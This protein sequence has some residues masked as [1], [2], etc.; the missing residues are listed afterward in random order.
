MENGVGVDVGGDHPSTFAMAG[1]SVTGCV[2]GGVNVGANGTLKVSGAPVVTGNVRDGRACNVYL[3]AGKTITVVG[4][5]TDGARIGVTTEVKPTADSS[6]VFTSGFGANNPGVDPSTFFVSDDPSYYVALEGGEAVLKPHT[7]A[8]QWESSDNVLTATCAN[9]HCTADGGNKQTLTLVAEG[10]TYDGRLA[11]ATVQ[12]S[13]GWAATGAAAGEVA[14]YAG[15][16]SLAVAPKDAGTY[17]ARVTVSAAGTPYELV[18]PFSIKKASLTVVARD[19]AVTFGEAPAG[20]GVTYAGFA[21]SE[22]KQVLSGTLAYEFGGCKAGSPIGT[23]PITPSGLWAPNYEISYRAG[24][25]TVCA[26]YSCPVTAVA[27]VQRKGSLA[28][29][30]G[31]GKVVGTTGSSLRLESLRLS[32]FGQQLSGSLEYRAHVQRVGWQGWVANGALAGTQGKSR[33]VEAFQMRL[34]GR[35]AQSYDIYYRVHAQ[36]YGWMAWAKNGQQAG[37][38]GKSLRIE[39]IQVVVIRKGSPAPGKTYN[40]VTQTYAKAFVKK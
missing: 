40:G 5:L 6:V 19:N 33:R 24:T 21:A 14:Y 7:H 23:Y 29:S 36:R 17:E 30:T 13:A 39:A 1:G 15:G 28:P 31:V 32:L 20:A 18:A 8:W 38:Q 3:P 34:T 11:S 37:T 35:M 9:E 16:K 4:A 27:H 25:L 2:G 22:G 26:S 10:K 12:E